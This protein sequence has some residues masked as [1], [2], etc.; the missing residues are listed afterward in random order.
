MRLF[1]RE[2]I[3]LIGITT[4]ILFVVLMI[5][6]LDGYRN[7]PTALYSV[8]I[9]YFLLS[10]YLLY[11]YA[12]HKSFYQ[13]LSKPME[14]WTERNRRKETAP[15]PTALFELLDSQHDRYQAQIHAYERKQREHVMFMNQWVHQMKTPLS[16]IHLTVQDDDDR[17]LESIREE[18]ERLG[19]GLEMVLYM[20]RLDTFEHDFRVDVVHLKQIANEII[21][22]NKSLFIRHFVYPKVLIDEELTVH[23][24]AKWLHFLLNQLVTNAIR[25]SS[26]T[27]ENVIVAAMHRGNDV[28][29]EVRDRGV[30]IPK[31]DQARV[32]RP[33]FTGENGRRFSESTGMGLYLVKE[34]CDR[35]GHSI[36]L[37]SEQGVGTTVRIVFRRTDS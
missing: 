6:W 19:K 9:G 31:H 15:L 8:F 16:V 21:H 3:P 11:R 35:L 28:V 25:Y 34:V 20:S 26:G 13:R 22:E 32:F 27:R 14:I 24:D 36:E 30:G 1:W 37:E 17:R 23:S 12:T 2:H 10:G 18:V 33:F 4:I 5:Y 29:L 7:V